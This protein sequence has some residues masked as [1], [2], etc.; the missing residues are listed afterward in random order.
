MADK[1]HRISIVTQDGTLFVKEQAFILPVCDLPIRVSVN[2]CLAAIG[3][4]KLGAKS[5]NVPVDLPSVSEYLCYVNSS[6]ESETVARGRWIRKFTVRKAVDE[7]TIPFKEGKVDWSAFQRLIDA[8][9]A[10][11]F[12]LCS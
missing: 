7:S 11:D 3:G 5:W 4:I 6:D 2:A 10:R 8:S 1:K 12:P 9:V